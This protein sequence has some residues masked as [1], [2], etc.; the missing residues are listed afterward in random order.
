MFLRTFKKIPLAV[1]FAL[2]LPAIA[3][4][5]FDPFDTETQIQPPPGFASDTEGGYQP[6]RQGKELAPLAVA[7][8]V[9]AALCANPRTREVWANARVQAA[10]VGVAQSAY[11]PSVSMTA[12]A[13]RDR[14]NGVSSDQRDL[15]VS[16]SWLLFDFGGRAATLENSRQLLVAASATQDA[17][18]QTVFL[19]AVQAFYQVLATRAALDA[20]NES[21]KAA[22]E[23]FNAADARYKAGAATPA[24][25]LQAQTA[26]SQAV[27]NRIKAEGNLKNAQGVLANVMGRDANRPVSLAS[28]QQANPPEHFEQNVDA[29]VDQARQRRPDLKAAEAAARAAAANVNAVKASGRPN[30]SFGINGLDQRTDGLPDAKT[31]TIGLTLTVPI[32]SGFDTN[33]RIRAA[34]AQAEARTAQQESLRLQVALDVWQAYQA[35]TTATQTFRSSADLLDSAT[36]SERVATGRYRAGVGNILDVLNAQSALASA[37]QQRVQALFGWNVAR[38]ALAQAMGTLDRGL[39]ATLEER[40]QP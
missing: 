30:L 29:L 34:E 28:T 39:I 26:W 10:Q 23:S 35:L 12:S 21:E 16:L 5:G 24:D 8:V 40:N 7:D 19:N 20:A 14:I 31:S 33:Y 13:N 2:A 6:C 22:R 27:L 37:R 17:T 1:L 15:G 4:E 9:D 36:E 32:F 38:V 3:R 18:V 11:L 25:K